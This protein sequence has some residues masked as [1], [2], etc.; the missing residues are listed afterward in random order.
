MVFIIATLIRKAFK[1]IDKVK[2]AKDI[3]E[4]W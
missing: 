4:L 2:E 1:K 3:E